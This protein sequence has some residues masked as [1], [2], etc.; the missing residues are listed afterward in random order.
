MTKPIFFS[1]CG[2]N[3]AVARGV[4]E[5][6]SSDLIYLYSDNGKQGADFPMEI[7][8]ELAECQCVVIFWSSDYIAES[9]P[10]TRR[11][12]ALAGRR[13]RDGALRHDLI[14]RLDETA[15]ETLVSNPLT[16]LDEDLLKPFRDT[17]RANGFPFDEAVL[18]QQLNE[19]LGVL[20]RRALPTLPRPGL[21][22]QLRQAL[23]IPGQW[24][25]KSPVIFVS[26]LEG[27]GR[28]TVINSVMGSAF[29]HLTR[30]TM[31]MDNI[32]TPEVNRP[33]N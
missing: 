6:F 4:Q 7:E 27:A 26:G 15:L 10:W 31:S 29:R 18:V 24:A 25:S 32:S 3:E 21:E 13:K 16:G 33:G 9:H 19:K 30:H 22:Q 14:I 8:R 17:T 11:E 28:S 1:V 5:K 2:T 12:L 20:G 23:E